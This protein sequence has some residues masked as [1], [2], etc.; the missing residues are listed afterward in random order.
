MSQLALSCCG[1]T[2]TKTNLV[3][4]EFNIN[5]R[6]QFIEGSQARTPE[7]AEAGTMEESYLLAFPQCLA[8]F[9]S[10]SIQDHVSR[11]GAATVG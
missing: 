11:H 10:Y 6:S 3:Q 5:I 8:Q 7:G 1:K 2:M 9:A 4:K